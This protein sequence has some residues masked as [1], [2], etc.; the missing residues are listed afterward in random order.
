[1]QS[2][3]VEVVLEVVVGVELNRSSRSNR[4][5]QSRAE[6][7]KCFDNCIREIIGN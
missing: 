6:V 4:Y 2:N 1:M 3:A 5:N 7:E